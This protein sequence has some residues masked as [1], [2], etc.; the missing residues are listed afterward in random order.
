MNFGM[1]MG[2]KFTDYGFNLNEMVSSAM[3]LIKNGALCFG[4]ANP[5][6]MPL[7]CLLVYRFPLH[8]AISESFFN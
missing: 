6:L 7:V 5:H 8:L 3:S 1:D 2:I 4:A